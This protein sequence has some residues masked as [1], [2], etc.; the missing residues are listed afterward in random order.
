MTKSNTNITRFTENDVIV[1]VSTEG[2]DE[3]LLS[4]VILRD[5][6]SNGA[7]S[8][9][10]LIESS[11]NTNNPE[12]DKE[13]SETVINQTVEKQVRS[14]L[15]QAGNDSNKLVELLSKYVNKTEE[16]LEKDIS[17][18]PICMGPYVNPAVSV[19]CWHTCCSE[20][21]LRVLGSKKLCPKCNNIVAPSQLRKI[22]L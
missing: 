14:I 1:P 13:N 15:S 19:S 17:K 3:E 9:K 5:A 4:A 2:S 10:S 8:S 20:C 22:Y 7:S 11:S 6:V 16:K 12:A 18:C 21:W